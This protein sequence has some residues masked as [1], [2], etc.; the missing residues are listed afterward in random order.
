MKE[1]LKDFIVKTITNNQ[2]PVDEVIF[3]HVL[4][5]KTD[6]L[7]CSYSP[8]FTVLIKDYIYNMCTLV[9]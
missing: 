5:N 3:N 8:R 4:L 1:S 7:T 9:G 6:I 2:K